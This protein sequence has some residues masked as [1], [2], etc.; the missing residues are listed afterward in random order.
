[1]GHDDLFGKTFDQQLKATQCRI[2]G[3]DISPN[4]RIPGEIVF[5]P[6]GRGV[7]VTARDA[8]HRVLWGY[9]GSKETVRQVHCLVAVYEALQSLLAEELAKRGL[10][11]P[12]AEPDPMVA[13]EEAFEALGDT[14]K[15]LR[16]SLEVKKV[17]EATRERARFIARL[18]SDADRQITLEARGL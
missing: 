3:R 10:F 17:T 5:E 16:E 15:R 6:A 12:E 14:V 11:N 4:R 8:E 7:R 13:A 1:M 2:E 9:I 18:I